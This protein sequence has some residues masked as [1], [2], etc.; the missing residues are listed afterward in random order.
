M[1]HSHEIVYA[2]ARVR[3]AN[4]RANRASKTTFKNHT[5][6]FGATLWDQSSDWYIFIKMSHE[7]KETRKTF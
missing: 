1:G 3:N 6:A 7:K 5:A 2:A 4:T